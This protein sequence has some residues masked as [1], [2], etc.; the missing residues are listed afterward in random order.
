MEVIDDMSKHLGVYVIRI[1]LIENIRNA[2][3][4]GKK[5]GQEVFNPWYLPLTVI[6]VMEV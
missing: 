6:N 2:Y 5:C 1:I 3:V 4:N